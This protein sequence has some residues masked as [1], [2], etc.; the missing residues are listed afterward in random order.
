[1]GY[2]AKLNQNS[3]NVRRYS[4]RDGIFTPRIQRIVQSS[5]SSSS[6]VVKAALQGAKKYKVAGPEVAF[7]RQS[8]GVQLVFMN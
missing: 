5:M 8:Y 3:W 6:L 2:A 7:P 1:M 4:A